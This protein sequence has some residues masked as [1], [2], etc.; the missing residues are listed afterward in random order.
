MML[1]NTARS[2]SISRKFKLL[3]QVLLVGMGIAL[4]AFPVR[5]ANQVILK[6]SVLQ[7]SISVPE[8]STL[9]YK[10]EVS[11][12]LRR[13]CKM[14][15][16]KPEEIQQILTK[17][18]EVDSVL[19]SKILNSPPGEFM[20]DRASEIVHTPTERAGRQSLRGALVTS[21][22][23]DNEIQIIEVIENYP[24]NE[25]HVDGD[26][27]VE[28]YNVINNVAGQLGDLEIKL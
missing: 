2:S 5:A 27:L 24:T 19:L 20:L 7:E 1:F 15:N 6:Y 18:V 22:V 9:A 11:P 17:E 26:R 23:P 25:V 12:S 13:Y 3:S 8:L 14:A 16:K 4:T 10:G 28:L 21:A